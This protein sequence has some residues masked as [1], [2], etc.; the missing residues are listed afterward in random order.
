MLLGDPQLAAR[1]SSISF[2][3]RATN[4]ISRGP[5]TAA[6]AV[7]SPLATFAEVSASARI[8][9][10]MGRA[11][12]YASNSPSSSAPKT[13]RA[14]RVSRARSDP[15]TSSV[16]TPE[17]TRQPDSGRVTKAHRRETP[18]TRAASTKPSGCPCATERSAP[19]SGGA[20]SKCPTHLS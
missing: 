16:G 5:E 20:G 14:V 11:I 1:T 12:R 8:G 2:T 7:V 10:A 3:C 17:K 6:R 15:K 19:G 13:M 18:S 4:L 9:L